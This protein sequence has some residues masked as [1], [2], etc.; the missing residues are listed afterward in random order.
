MHL[1][2]TLEIL[3]RLA[4]ERL[5]E[6][7][8]KIG[9]MVG[10]PAWNIRRALLCIDLTE[11]VLD[12]AIKQRASLIVAYHPPI[13][14]ALTALTTLDVKQRIILRAAQRRIAVYSPHTALDAVE[15]GVNDWLCIG[16]GKG[17]R[18]PIKP[19]IPKEDTKPY[20]LVVFVPD[21][22][23]DRLRSALSDAG[24]GVI[25]DY[26][27]C[28]FGVQGH[29]TFQGGASTNPQ[30]GQRGRF[31]TVSE[32]RM[33]MVCPRDCLAQAVAALY[34]VHP[35]EEPAFDLYRLELPPTEGLRHSSVD[36]RQGQ[37]RVVT[38]A[39][40]VAPSTLI[41]R[42]KSHLE[43]KQLRVAVPEGLKKIQCVGLCAGAGGSLLEEAGRVDAFLTGEMRHHDILAAKARGVMILLTGHTQTERPYLPVYRQRILKAGGDG[44]DWL[45][46]SADQPPLRVC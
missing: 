20:K 17:H 46:S 34:R 16:M 26:T 12:E 44:I 10:D 38:L 22:D 7:W 28:S 21:D 29:G 3:R 4:P 11:A 1:R 35:Y 43:I 6:P 18:R 5:A 13:F 31:E 27:Q 8:D 30:V 23:A 41:R 39:K 15:D 14:S 40:P 19:V 25:G 24:A 45:I 9:L 2:N 33:E 42:V 37:G 36:S 32:L